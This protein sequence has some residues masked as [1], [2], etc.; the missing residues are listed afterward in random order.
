[1]YRRVIPRDLFNEAKL[2][3]CLGRLALMIHNGL[4]YPLTF[5]HY[6]EIHEGFLIDQ[7]QDS[8]HL[9]C[10]NMIFYLND[11]ALV[12][13]TNY[14]SKSQYPLI[15]EDEELGDVCVFDD[16]GNFSDEFTSYLNS[17]HEGTE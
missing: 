4:E 11:N 15:F 14:N 2:L 5:E 9:F 10:R 6:T 13:G 1:M 16:D 8:G 3:K 17:H 12:L 7:D